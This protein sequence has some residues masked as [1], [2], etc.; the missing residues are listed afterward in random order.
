[1]APGEP[2]GEPGAPNVAPGEPN[3]C[4]GEPGGAGRSQCGA[5]R[6]FSLYFEGISEPDVASGEPIQLFEPRRS[7]EPE[8]KPN[9]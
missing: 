7:V 3:V 2:N 4:P 8:A 9:I 5:G 6:P 1:M